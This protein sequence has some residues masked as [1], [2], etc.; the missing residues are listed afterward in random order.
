[1]LNGT[2]RLQES[3]HSCV[4]LSRS[5][6]PAN[7]TLRKKTETLAFEMVDPF[8][9]ALSPVSERKLL[10]HGCSSLNK[11][12]CGSCRKLPVRLGTSLLRVIAAVEGK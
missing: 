2:E 3:I 1:M 8:S 10:H 11:V 9:P 12:T 6:S 5:Q 7:G 4:L